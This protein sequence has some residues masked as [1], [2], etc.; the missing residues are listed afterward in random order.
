MMFM[1]YLVTFISTI[2]LTAKY[3]FNTKTHF[4][5]VLINLSARQNR[6]KVMNKLIAHLS[7]EELNLIFP[8][9]RNKSWWDNFLAFK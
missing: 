9:A 5:V 1:T 4:W 8:M 7:T 3:G 6:S 2:I